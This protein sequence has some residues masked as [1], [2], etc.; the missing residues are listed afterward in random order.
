MVLEMLLLYLAQISFI[1]F[2]RAS[3]ISGEK[4]CEAEE[5]EEEEE[6]EDEEEGEEED[7]ET[8]LLV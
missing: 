6:T 3:R 5:E 7:K 2:W 1:N 8:L 4:D